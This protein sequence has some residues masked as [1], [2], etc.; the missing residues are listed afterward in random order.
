MTELKN[1]RKFVETM[2]D[3]FTDSEGLAEYLNN[4][5]VGTWRINSRGF[6]DVKGD[7][8]VYNSKLDSLPVKFGTVSGNFNFSSSRHTTSLV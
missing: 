3:R 6:I 1:F 5:I 8:N 2:E 7:V 4:R